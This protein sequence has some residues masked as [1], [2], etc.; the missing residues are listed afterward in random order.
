MWKAVLIVLIGC[1]VFGCGS[2]AVKE[3]REKPVASEEKDPDPYETADSEDS[4][5]AQ[6]PQKGYFDPL[7]DMKDIKKERE[8]DLE[9][10]KELVDEIDN[11]E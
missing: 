7:R 1:F 10:K 4:E 5:E 9:K 2:K 6:D 11:Q 8:E 3:N